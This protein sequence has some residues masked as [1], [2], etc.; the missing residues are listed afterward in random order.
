MPSVAPDALRQP[1]IIKNA[2]MRRGM[3][4]LKDLTHSDF[5]FIHPLQGM[6]TEAGTSHKKVFLRLVELT[7]VEPASVECQVRPL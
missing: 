7:G 4:G 2:L 3:K 1:F 6:T 5:S